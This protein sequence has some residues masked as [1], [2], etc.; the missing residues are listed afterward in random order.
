MCFTHHFSNS[1]FRRRWKCFEKPT[2]ST[3][4]LG[5]SY[6]EVTPM[7]TGHPVYATESVLSSIIRN[8]FIAQGYCV[9][10]LKVDALCFVMDETLYSCH[11]SMLLSEISNGSLLRTRSACCPVTICAIR[12]SVTMQ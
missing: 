1:H 7:I 10:A 6:V 9:V 5:R 4:N 12:Y 2:T 11:E 8:S 3:I